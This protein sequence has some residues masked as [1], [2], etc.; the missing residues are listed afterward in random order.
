MSFPLVTKVTSDRL[1]IN[2]SCKTLAIK[3]N[4]IAAILTYTLVPYHFLL[5]AM[6]HTVFSQCLL[7]ELMQ[8][9][10]GLRWRMRTALTAHKG[11]VDTKSDRG[12]LLPFFKHCV[13]ALCRR[14]QRGPAA[15]ATG[16]KSS[17]GIH[18]QLRDPNI[19]G[20]NYRSVICW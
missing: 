17:V 19:D 5:A 9:W 15:T 14:W 18:M 7:I 2:S 12:K 11:K 13:S 8:I 10:F 16:R 6:L 3:E 4:N 1:G 20:G